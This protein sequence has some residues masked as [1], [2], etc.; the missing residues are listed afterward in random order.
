MKKQVRIFVASPGDVGQERL[1]A[2]RVIDRLQGEFQ[3]VIEIIP[4][5]WEHEPLRATA[6]YQEELMNPSEADI[7]VSILWSRLGTR[8]PGQFVREDGSSFASGT[9]WEFEVSAD[10]FKKTNKPDIL[11]YR[12]TQMVLGTLHDEKALEEKIKQKKA[13]DQFCDNWFG[14]PEKG[15]SNAFHTFE[16]PDEFEKTLENHLRRTLKKFVPEFITDEGGPRTISWTQGSPFRG[17]EA[18][19]Y[20]HADVFFGRTKAISQVKDAFVRRGTENTA[21]VLILGM[22]GSGKSSL[23]RA[24]V[25]PTITQPGVIEGVA[26]WRYGVMRPTDATEGD[27]LHALSMM[28]LSDSALPEI[29]K[30]GYDAQKLATAFRESTETAIHIIQMAL[31]DVS[32]G[33]TQKLKLESLPKTRLSLLIDQLEE[34]FTLDQLSQQEIETFLKIIE[35]LAQSGFVYI[36]GTMRSDFYHRCADYPTLMALKEGEGQYHL[37]PP[38]FVEIGQMIRQPAWAAG[39]TFEMRTSDHAKLD[40]VLHEEAAEAPENLTLLQFTLEELWRRREQDHILTFKAYAE[41]GGL[42]G[43]LAKRAEE[44]FLSCPFESQHELVKLF[45]ALVTLDAD[46]EDRI[47]ARRI[48]LKTIDHNEHVRTLIQSFI[49]ARLLVSDA[50]DRGEPVIRLA[51]EAL[52][53]YWPRLQIWIKEN[54]DFLRI[55]ARIMQLA[56]RWVEENKQQAYLLAQG[57]PL[58]EGQELLIHRDDLDDKT[59]GFIETSLEHENLRLVKQQ[60][61]EKRKMQILVATSGVF[62]ILAIFAII[63][64][65]FGYEGRKKAESQTTVAQVERDKA[66]KSQGEAEQQTY[67]AKKAAHRAE[68]SMG[69]SL[70]AQSRAALRNERSQKEQSHFLSNLAFRLIDQGEPVKAA[71][72]GLEALPES[73]VVQDRPYVALSESVLYKVLEQA[74]EPTI[75]EGIKS[76]PTSIASSPDQT[77][78]ASGDDQGNVYLWKMLDPQKPLLLKGHSKNITNVDF[79][80]DGHQVYSSSFD[81]SVRFFDVATGKMVHVID[82]HIGPIVKAQ[83]YKNSDLFVL[84]ES[85]E[86]LLYRNHNKIFSARQGQPVRFGGVSGSTKFIV[87]AS[88]NGVVN[89][90]DAATQKIIR[91]FTLEHRIESFHLAKAVDLCIFGLSNGHIIVLDLNQKEPVVLRGHMGSVLDVEVSDDGH[92]LVSGSIDGTG[93]VWDLSTGKILKTLSGHQGAINFVHLSHDGYIATSSYD[94]VVRIWRIVK[95]GNVTTIEFE[96]TFHVE[97]KINDIEFYGRGTSFLIATPDKKVLL[98]KIKRTLVENT[99]KIEKQKIVKLKYAPK[100]GYLAIVLNNNVC[101]VFNVLTKKYVDLIGHQGAITDV[102]FDTEGQ[103]LVTS[104]E[105]GTLRLWR[106]TDGEPLFTF[107]GHQGAVKNI[108]YDSEKNFILSAG[109]DDYLYFW[110]TLTGTKTDVLKSPEKGIV[111]LFYQKEK[112]QLIGVTNTGNLY[113]WDTQTHQLIQHYFPQ[114]LSPFV[115]V[116]NIRESMIAL[117]FES[118]VFVYDFVQKKL[119]QSLDMKEGQAVDLVITKDQKYIITGHLDGTLKKWVLRTGY[120][121]KLLKAHKSTITTLQLNTAGN[122]MISLGVEGQLKLW[123]TEQLIPLNTYGDDRAAIQA[124]SLSPLETSLALSSNSQEISMNK[125]FPTTE[126]IISHVRKIVKRQLTPEERK[127]YYLTQF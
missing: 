61:Q 108:I 7:V 42:H 124:F 39:L 96:R 15:F 44:I 31:E 23:A 65:Y 89:V 98:F 112:N 120:L 37:L 9:E 40:D 38:N 82:E 62:G 13:L 109:D 2:R 99:F 66:K 83:I 95:E 93:H 24:G 33:E 58:L 85:G 68:L 91:T 117:S 32:K 4:I 92:L 69:A 70:V 116:S 14:N 26:F 121:Y 67:L 16:T 43:A 127:E 73:F 19:D 21:F 36:I 17:L 41:L 6:H 27:M 54:Q 63:G 119:I 50:D 79:T 107:Y 75:F 88:S 64:G 80:P 115:K 8:L 34:L 53:H 102:A 46:H 97:G 123:D 114:A 57:K 29:K 90:W 81:G 56:E 25:L 71:L 10:S 59:I 110:D 52:L 105:D 113:V 22:S 106:H 94:G 47:A 1:I 74:H 45:R 18:F 122:H 51:H 72:L 20:E 3:N 12:K 125:V 60:L 103:S 111:N 87:T 76:I 11:V 55:R 77:Y 48:A 126:D 30:Q 104:S 100:G 101:R 78:A 118:S 84:Y 28:L 35:K 5:L 86:A 49:G